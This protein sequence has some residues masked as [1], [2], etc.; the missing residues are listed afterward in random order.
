[1]RAPEV[2]SAD[3]WGAPA[4]VYSFAMCLYALWARFR[5]LDDR[6]DARTPGAPT[7][8]QRICS[9]ARFARDGAIPEYYWDLITRCWRA[10]PQARPSFAEILAELMHNRAWV[11][12]GTDEEAL[13]AYEA[14]VRP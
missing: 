1:M 4:D 10:D 11:L 13:A 6:A 2:Y 3:E 12:L 14:K 8:I 7:V 5:R 9:G